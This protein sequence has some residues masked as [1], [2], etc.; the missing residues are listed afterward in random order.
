[1]KKWAKF[2]PVFLLAVGLA[3]G[4][5]AMAGSAWVSVPSTPDSSGKV[6][7]KG[8]NLTAWSEVTVS[9]ELPDGTKADQV[10]T[11]A[12]DGAISVEYLAGL[13]GG[14]AVKVFDQ[15]GKEIGKGNFSYER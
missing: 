9:I 7:I 14:Y 5:S 3:Y 12:D 4:S 15:D 10:Q 2:L 1:M 6:V 8:G 11:I 13:T